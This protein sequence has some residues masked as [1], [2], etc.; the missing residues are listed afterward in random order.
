MGNTMI[1]PASVTSS[2]LNMVWSLFSLFPA[3]IALLLMVLSYK[4][5]I[6]K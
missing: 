4:F 3:A 5:P 1:D 6:K 2:V